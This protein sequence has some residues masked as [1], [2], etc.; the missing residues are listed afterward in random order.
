MF[1]LQIKKYFTQK[2]KILKLELEFLASTTRTLGIEDFSL[3]SFV[4][5]WKEMDDQPRKPLH[6][7][8][9]MQEEVKP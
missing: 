3:Q 5:F 1:L 9:Q 6:S 8:F 2:G 7:H 4:T